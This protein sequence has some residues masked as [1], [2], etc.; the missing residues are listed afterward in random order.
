MTTLVLVFCIYA[1]DYPISEFKKYNTEKLTQNLK[2]Y[3]GGKKHKKDS[4]IV[5]FKQG[6]TKQNIQDILDIYGLTI[7]E[8]FHQIDAY[9]IEVPKKYQEANIENFINI[10][11]QN[12]F[13]K[14]VN[15]NGVVSS[16]PTPNN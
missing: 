13:V 3:M 7:K 9:L 1:T 5:T 15:L 12:N 16:L 10:L 4:I 14:S 6:I 2:D 11:K 8:D